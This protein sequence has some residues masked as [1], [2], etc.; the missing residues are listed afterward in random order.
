MVGKCITS[1]I[2]TW[3]PVGVQL[4]ALALQTVFGF[5]FMAP[6]ISDLTTMVKLAFIAH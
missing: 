4:A 3:V 5:E 6:V 1:F 2:T